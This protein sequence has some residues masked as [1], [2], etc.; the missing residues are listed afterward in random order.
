MEN[1]KAT[2]NM[3]YLQLTQDFMLVYN[4]SD[5]LEIGTTIQILLVAQM[6]WNLRHKRYVQHSLWGNFMKKR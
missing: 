2:K 3:S 6:I 4:S 5:D 1:W